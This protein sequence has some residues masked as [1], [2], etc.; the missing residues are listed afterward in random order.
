[1]LVNMKTFKIA[2]KTNEVIS[3]APLDFISGGTSGNDLYIVVKKDNGLELNEGGKL[4]FEKVASG[5]SGEMLKVYEEN[6][7]IKK[8]VEAGDYLYVYFEYV[9]IKPLTLASYRQIESPEGYKFK[10]Y[11]TGDHHMLPCDLIDDPNNPDDD[12]KIYIRR[13]E[14]VIEFSDLALCFPGG[15]VEGC[16]IVSSG[17]E[18]CDDTVQRFNYETMERNSILAKVKKAVSGDEDDFKPTPGDQVLFATNPFFHIER[19]TIDEEKVE[20]LI[21][22]PKNNISKEDCNGQPISCDGEVVSILKYTDFMR[23]GVVM[24]QDYD[25]KRMFQEYQANELFVKK[26]KNSIIPDFIDLEKVKYA[27]AYF[28]TDET[29]YLATGLT[30]NLHFRT[31]VSGDSKYEF[32]DTWHF[33]D[34]TNTWNGSGVTDQVKREDLY[35]DSSFVNSSNLMG[36]LGFTD[37]D[38]YNQKN[39]VKQSFIRLSFYDGPNPLTQN[40]LYYS[41]IFVDSGELFGKFVKRKAWL[42]EVIDDYD[43]ATY[44]VVW[45]SASTEDPCDAITC[46]LIVNDEYD[47]TRSGEGF[48]IYLF[49]QNAPIENYPQDIYMK[50]E[51]NHAGYGRTV[52]MIYWPKENGSPKKL[53]AQNYLENLYIHVRISLTERGYVYDFP[54][55][56]SAENDDKRKNGIVWENERLVLNLFEPMIEPEILQ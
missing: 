21:L 41:T 18:C 46:Q 8:I 37:D 2:K 50:V 22:Y 28:V 47:M 38:I 54:Q 45:S 27:P 44:P 32:E 1:M 43:P 48:N 56:V 23:L 36:F 11:F 16:D 9:Y 24:E 5:S 14:K 20:K 7:E 6:T 13:G 19:V 52:P 51:F 42:E 40:L 25:A 29:M 34:A 10:L 26:V 17:G 39:R 4:L 55:V 53:T 35:H 15:L 49:R 30:F 31:R 12:Y 33:N 3:T